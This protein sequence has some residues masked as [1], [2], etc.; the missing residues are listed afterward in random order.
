[1]SRLPQLGLE[2]IHG[3]AHQAGS[4]SLLT[5]NVFF[6]IRNRFH[7]HYHR[8][9]H[10]TIAFFISHL[11][12]RYFNGVIDDSRFMGVLFGLEA[13]AARRASMTD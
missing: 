4:D 5:S 6:Q 11:N 8:S 13:S 12:P 10:R 2:R 3:P 7:H 1:M 9:R